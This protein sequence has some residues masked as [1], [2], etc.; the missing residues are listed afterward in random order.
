MGSE[1]EGGSNGRTSTT[2]VTGDRNGEGEEAM[3]CGH[4]CRGGGEEAPWCRR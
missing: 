2:P 1:G 3:G 4:F